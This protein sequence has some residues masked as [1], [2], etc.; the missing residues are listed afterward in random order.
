MT[1]RFLLV[2]TTVFAAA[3]QQTQAPPM[4]AR[5]KKK[6][7]SRLRKELT[8]PYNRWL[9]Q[10]VAWIITPDERA[11]FLKL[12]TDDEREQF[13]EQFWL[14]RDPTPDT[15]E[16]EFREEHYRRI[17]YANERFASGIPGWKT[18]RG[19][20]YIAWGPPDE[21]DEHAS[22][23]S[24]Q[25]TPEEGGGTTSTFPFEI[26]R[27]RHLDGVDSDV[28][29]EFIDPTMSGE[30]RLTID[31]CEKDALAKVPGAGPTQ[32]E[33]M[34]IATRTD[35]FNTNGT[36]CGPS[37][38]GQSEK[39]NQFR[40][41]ELISKVF[42][43]PAVKF[44]D[45]KAVVESTV[46]YNALPMQVL[47]SYFPLTE[48]SVLTYVTLKFENRDLTFAARDAVDRAGVNIEGKVSTMSRRSVTPF[49]ASVTVEAPHQMV[50]DLVRGRSIYNTSLPLAPGAYRLDIAAKDTVGGA[51]THYQVALAVPRLDPEKL[52]L[53]SIVLTD[54]LEKVAPRS[55]G[56]GQFVIGDL[57]VR[58]RLDSRFRR[59]ERLGIYAKAYNAGPAAHVEYEIVK[60]GA[61]EKLYAAAEDFRQSEITIAKPIDLRDF[62]PG[63]YTLR[64]RITGRGQ[65]TVATAGFTVQ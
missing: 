62:A 56:A 7:E 5:E 55:I 6:Q 38:F 17:A 59:D 60:A 58:P 14:R 54:V 31:P 50:A 24:Y 16:N 39:N 63:A 61:T 25:R 53:S 4:S 19:R 22:G 26:W 36:S 52:Q 48:A 40:R 34:G 37:L 47:V 35:R 29:L 33:S 11:A 3:A 42:A 18:D 64:L 1:I 32:A 23:G 46:K 30:Y 43:P 27:Y 9:D 44:N 57:K 41:L 20:I 2:L 12:Q 13:I 21:R 28:Q 65:T 45:L 49:E 8:A 15:V 51:V 10:D